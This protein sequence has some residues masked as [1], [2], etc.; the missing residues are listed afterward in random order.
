MSGSVSLW[1]AFD[2]FNVLSSA[3]DN[4]YTGDQI[5]DGTAAIN[6]WAT[7]G[8]AEDDDLLLNGSN[9]TLTYDDTNGWLQQDTGSTPWELGSGSWTVEVR[10]KVGSTGT[11]NGGFV[12]WAALNGNR[13]ILT[14]RENAVMSFAG[15]V[16]ESSS[17]TD[18][19]HDFRL[20]YDA[21]ANAYHYFRDAVQLTPLVGVAPQATT[22]S[23]RLIFGDCCTSVAGSTFG[24][25]GES[26]DIEYV[27]YD[28]TGAYSPTSD[29]G[30]TV[31]TIDRSTGNITL[32]NT[33]GTPVANIVGYSL[34]SEAGGLTQTG[35]IQ[36]ASGSQLANDNDNWTVTTAAGVTTDL[37]EAV[38]TTSGSG[39]GGDLLAGT[40]SWNFGNVWTQ[41]PFEDVQL[42]LLLDDGTVLNSG[43][44]FQLV[45]TGNDDQA[46]A[47]GDL[48]GASVNDGPDGDIDLVD[49]QKFKSVY[50]SDVTGFTQ[51]SAYLAGDLNGDGA[52]DFGDFNAFRTLYD[53]ANGPGAF[54]AAVSGAAVPE[55]ATW[56][57]AVVGVVGFAMRRR[58]VCL[59]GL[60]LACGA[61]LATNATAQV[62]VAIFS[63]D[64]QAYPLTDPSDFSPT[65]NWT[66]NGNGTA[67]NADRIF[68][69]PNYGGTRLWI[70]SAANAAAGSG[71]DS[72][73]ITQAEGFLSNTDYT[74]SAAFVTETFNATRTA[75]GTYD[76]LVGQSFAS[77]TSVVGGP[78]AFTA[79]GD[80]DAS[81]E[82]TI[83]DSYDDQ[84]TTLAFNSGTVNAGDQLFITF[85][86]DGVDASNAFVAVDEVEILAQA[87]IGARVNTTTGNITLFGDDLFD[88]DITGYSLTSALGQLIPENLTSL[89]SQGIGDASMTADDGIGFEVLGTPSTTEVAEGHLTTFTTFTESTNLS[90]GNLFDTT[91]PEG[92]RD[93]ALTLSTVS[94]EELSAVIEYVTSVNVQGD[95]NGD[96]VVNLGDYTVWRDNLGAGDESAINNNGD[97]GGVTMSDYTYWKERFGNS[98]SGAITAQSVAVPEP[99]AALLLVVGMALLSCRR[100]SRAIAF[101]AC[102]C[103]VCVSTSSYAVQID[104]QYDFGDDPDESASH[105]T[106]MS[107]ATYD[108]AGTLG[109]GDLQ[110]LEVNGSPTYVSVSSRPGALSSDLGAQ[111]NGTSD[112]LSTAISLNAPSQM[113]DNSTFFP[114][115]APYV[116]PHNYEG[117][118]THGIQLWAQPNQAAL[119]TASQ[120]LISDANQHGIG[121]SA[122]GNWELIYRGARFDTEVPVADT[123]DENGWA[124]V[125]EITRPSGGASGGTLIINGTAV[126]TNAASYFADAGPLVVGASG[127]GSGGFTNHYNGTLDDVRLF[128]WGDNSNQLGA[129]NAVGG[130]NSGGPDPTPIVL[131]AD[132]QD[133]GGLDLGTTSDWIAQQLTTLGITDPGDVDLS[134][135]LADAAD[136]AAFVSFWRQQQTFNGVRIGDWNSRQEGDLNY[137]GIVDLRDAFILHESLT[138]SGAGGFNFALLNG[139][140]VPEPKAMT[141]T[142]CLLLGF[143][144]WARSAR[145]RAT[146]SV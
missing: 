89:E 111:F 44:D 123:L 20:V 60:T 7:A 57:S 127:D 22:G 63:D 77:A 2:G 134:G 98:A 62:P 120:T 30:A 94:G 64:F 129:D 140:A 122:E 5:F 52:S 88:F 54:A 74:F 36:Q 91:T 78:Q 13:D 104:R 33:T 119:G 141:L 106:S 29:Q 84:R 4:Q 118:F 83:D 34:L 146:M 49:W 26:F 93:L 70:A 32:T 125:M 53:A 144:A 42:E 10:A 90:L 75:T 97:G 43:T 114:G 25:F 113:W 92:E 73:G 105:G 6:G 68:D 18:A 56:L 9:V 71:L 59:L 14:I 101:A 107:G 103:L 19:F 131:N 82:G 51:V 136:E 81:I 50:G 112:A 12:I 28:M 145:H 135:G 45:Y 128:L 133:W 86:Y 76:L 15:T 8:G 23:T 132:G 1:A 65:G 24:G 41:S 142:L 96:G 27:R 95:F 109:A 3:F 47:F 38:F 130:T 116:F 79:Q 48:A 67:P 35:W 80:F 55:P 21:S 124:H 37:S 138:A 137:D 58:A 72:R 121:I 139:A 85:A 46:F 31:V 66:H 110:D 69:T 108:S 102:V 87:D 126:F 11:G 143:V 16:Y 100:A 61:M 115:P 17:N 39:D 40:G 99:T 117:I